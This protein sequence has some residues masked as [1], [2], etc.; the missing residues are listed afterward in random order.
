MPPDFER[1]LKNLNVK[2]NV[3]K[4]VIFNLPNTKDPDTGK[5]CSLQCDVSGLGQAAEYERIMRKLIIYPNKLKSMEDYLVACIVS[6][7]GVPPK[8]RSRY[9]FLSLIRPD[10]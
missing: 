3:T 8:T 7:Y 4:M 9:F 5:P 6:D 2:V 1:K 10:E